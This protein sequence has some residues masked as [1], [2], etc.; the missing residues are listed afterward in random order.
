MITYIIFTT[1]TF[2][3]NCSQ[4]MHEAN[5]LTKRIVKYV[6]VVL[7]LSLVF[8]ITRFFEAKID[9]LHMYT[10]DKGVERIID[11][12]NEAINSNDTELVNILA[13]ISSM[14]GIYEVPIIGTTRMRTSNIYITYHNWSKLIVMGLI[15]YMTL[16]I[17][18]YK[19][20]QVNLNILTTQAIGKS[21]YLDR[22]M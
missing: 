21:K 17:L 11:H 19:I 9:Y 8:T 6:S 14:Y 13:N 12:Y 5:A 16:I 15:P 10:D 7:F 1:K 22:L 2:Q 20:F 18:N 3:Y 4:A